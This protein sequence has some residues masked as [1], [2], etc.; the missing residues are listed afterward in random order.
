M[1]FIVFLLC[2]D[3][4]YC[5]GMV[6]DVYVCMSLDIPANRRIVRPCDP[7]CTQ[8]SEEIWSKPGVQNVYLQR[9]LAIKMIKVQE[10]KGP[11]LN[12]SLAHKDTVEMAYLGGT[13]LDQLTIWQTN[14]D[15]IYRPIYERSFLSKMVMFNSYTRG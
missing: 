1:S 3:V 12:S 2:C 6:W 7:P 8:I 10:K 4:L 14:M 9:I 5:H 15:M 13:T 11:R